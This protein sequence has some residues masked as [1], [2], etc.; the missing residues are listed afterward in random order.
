M[1]IPCKYYDNIQSTLVQH[2]E[3]SWSY[4][5]LTQTVLVHPMFN[6]KLTGLPD[7]TAIIIFKDELYKVLSKFNQPIY[8]KDLPSNVQRIF[9]GFNFNQPLDNDSLPTSITHLTF[10]SSFDQLI[11]K[12]SLPESVTHLSFGYS[13]NQPLD[14]DSL[15][16]S[17]T[18]LTFGFCFNQPVNKD[19]L[20][21]SIT[22]LTFGNYFNQS[23]NEANLPNSLTHLIFGHHF[24]QPIISLPENLI[25]LQLGA[26]YHHLLNNLPYGLKTLRISKKYPIA[27]KVPFGCKIFKLKYI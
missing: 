25:F 19:S 1:D 17:I 15:P 18:H 4:D 26:F 20:P 7:D 24:D 16:S 12:D 27:N 22:H 23:V 21:N 8:K 13:F 3:Y 11:N 2:M 6:D 10:G 9:F 14:K 5:K